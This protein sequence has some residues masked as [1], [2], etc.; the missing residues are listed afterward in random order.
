MN[1]LSTKS[2]TWDTIKEKLEYRGEIGLG[3]TLE[4]Q[5]H[6]TKATIQNASELNTKSPEGGCLVICNDLL[7]MF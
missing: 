5:N 7:G 3:I 2:K 4:C 1:L 6:G